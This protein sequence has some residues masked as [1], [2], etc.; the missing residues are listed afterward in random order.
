MNGGDMAARVL[1]LVNSIEASGPPYALEVAARLTAVHPDLLR[2]YCMTGLL[3]E[4]HMSPDPAMVFD[5]NALYAVRRIE[6]LRRH[7][8][9]NRRTLPLV[10]GLIRESERLHAELRFLR[11]R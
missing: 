7:H 11:N 9:V 10:I 5:D 3:G 1:V 4:K 8:G 6:Y 2:Y